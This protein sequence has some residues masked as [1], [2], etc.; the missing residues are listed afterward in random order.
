VQTLTKLFLPFLSVECA[1]QFARVARRRYMTNAL[2]GKVIVVRFVPSGI[3][4]RETFT[5]TYFQSVFKENNYVLDTRLLDFTFERTRRNV[6]YIR[7]IL[8]Y[9]ASKCLQGK[10]L[11]ANYSARICGY[12]F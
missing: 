6:C 4:I 12:I 11:C 8:N 7:R 10:F 3:F 9:P 5:A 2:H 1:I